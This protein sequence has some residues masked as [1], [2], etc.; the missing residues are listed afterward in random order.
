[1]AKIQHSMK[2]IITELD[3]KIAQLEGN[4]TKVS[5]KKT[6]KNDT[7]LK[8]MNGSLDAAKKAKTLLMDSCC[9]GQVCDF[10]ADI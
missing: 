1:M 9:I 5:T 6:A 7:A 4:I 3:A 10:D 8:Q 2:E